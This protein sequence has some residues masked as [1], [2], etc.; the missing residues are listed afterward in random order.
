MIHYAPY[1]DRSNQRVLTNISVNHL[2]LSHVSIDFFRSCCPLPTIFWVNPNFI[3]VTLFCIL[4][5]SFQNK[6]CV[7]GCEE[8][9]KWK[10]IYGDFEY[11][12]LLVY[13]SLGF[14]TRI[15]HKNDI[16][17]WWFSFFLS[18]R[19]CL[20]V[21]ETIVFTY[22]CAFQIIIKHIYEKP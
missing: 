11:F 18:L 10:R 16:V 14:T 6:C 22:K 2:F 3:C 19:I 8:S 15:E 9:T 20:S 21:C 5:F 17:I 4:F 7:C 13:A 12:S 1:S